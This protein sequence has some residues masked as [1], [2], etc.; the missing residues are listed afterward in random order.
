M[1]GRA[2]FPRA[3]RQVVNRS[4]PSKGCNSSRALS[5]VVRASVRPALQPP[6]EGP[7]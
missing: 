3:I 7:D 2:R 6:F 4:P 1:R 5:K